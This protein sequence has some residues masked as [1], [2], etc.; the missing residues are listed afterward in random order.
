MK[1][2]WI[3]VLA[4]LVVAGCVWL[5]WRCSNAAEAAD[6][7]SD[8]AHSALDDAAPETLDGMPPDALGTRA[9]V[10]GSEADTASA[11]K[12]E[13][14]ARFSSD[15]L[16]QQL[17]LVARAE[18]ALAG[19]ADETALGVPT[20]LH[21]TR[22]RAL[23]D[24]L[25][26]LLFETSNIAAILD[27][28]RSGTLAPD[29]PGNGKLSLAEYGAV[30]SLYWTIL[31]HAAPY[32][33]VAQSIEVD[34]S[35]LIVS[36]LSALPEL[37]PRVAQRLLDQL[38]AARIDGVL[39]LDRRFLGE[40]L[41][42]RRRFP[43]HAA[44]FSSL[45]DAMAESMAPEERDAIFRVLLDDD[46]DSK[47]IAVALTSLL[48]GEDWPTALSVA[49][50]L[51]DGSTGT[52]EEL[53]ARRAAI[54]L[55]VAVNTPDPYE[56]VDF[57]TQRADA[58]RNMLGVYW[59]LAARE[60]ARGALEARYHELAA[61]DADP[62]ARYLMVLGLERAEPDQMFA[63]AASDSDARVRGQALRN[64]FNSE[65]YAVDE[66]SLAIL[67]SYSS[68]ERAASVAGVITS[69]R[70][71]CQRASKQGRRG[72]VDGA[73]EL[74]ERHARDRRLRAQDRREAIEALRP[75][76]DTP[77]YEEL[78]RDLSTTAN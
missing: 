59:Q 29:T 46:A 49:E 35:A 41:D 55:A 72:V 68:G 62:R 14:G 44:L 38:A 42:L 65:H 12:R 61:A 30:R 58:T 8:T 1:R 33:D 28:L 2:N 15:A 31:T 21:E 23:E 43:D 69:A 76:V 27:L 63:I 54:A 45:L 75:Y 52:A 56:A 77:E 60:D 20:E 6:E 7:G 26:P 4:V 36:I 3:V 51:F 71:L 40:I 32:S 34:A 66:R 53:G 5:L 67:E 25:E 48:Q 18:Q 73:V 47:M 50:T 37:D 13:R 9:V 19:G 11:P 10:V 39:V 16:R 78:L 17:E 70:I 74:L 24:A 64:A 22:R 57:L